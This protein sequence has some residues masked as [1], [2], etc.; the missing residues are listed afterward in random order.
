MAQRD[1]TPLA[2]AAVTFTAH[3]LVAGRYGFFR[4]ELYFIDCGR[5]PALGYAD[6]PPLAPLIAALTQLAGPNLVL[7]RLLPALAHALTVV[8]AATLAR[9]IAVDAGLGGRVAAALTAAA[10]ALSPMYL[11]L[12]TTFG[13][14]TF[15]PLAWTA[16]ALL[17]ARAVSRHDLRALVLAGAVAGIAM[18]FKYALPFYLLPLVVGLIASPDRRVLFNR[19]AAA[20]TAIALLLAA[21][22]VLWQWSHGWPFLE[23]L[24]AAKEKNVA[25]S[26]LEF[27][28]NQVLVMNPVL[29]PLW[30]AGAIVPF[31]SRRFGRVRFLAVGFVGVLLEM[32]FLHGK[33]YYPAPGYA[34]AFALGSSAVEA[35]MPR[36]GS[37]RIAALALALIVCAVAAPTAMPILDPPSLAAY[38]RTLHLGGQ[39]QEKNA[40]GAPIPQ[41]FADMLGW[42]ELEA[43]VA[44]AFHALTPQERARVAIVTSNYGE[45]AALDFFGGKDGL[46]PA[47][48]GHN[49]FY[50]WGP[51]G[52]DGS[53]VLRINGNIERWR[54]ICDDVRLVGT[55][56]VEYSLVYEKDRPILLCRG[57]KKRLDESWSDFK[58]ID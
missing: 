48:S 12:H 41:E 13:T 4:D 28:G 58:H 23:L 30:M 33:D 1:L 47:L 49:Q 50:F 19:Q 45:A 40:V 32:M 36:M 17:V 44:K 5:H 54:D 8:T 26:S 46:P 2:I 10:V 34:A 7:L 18:E 6:Q 43:R 31:L 51:R 39:A 16:I 24:G 29:A 53:V 14:T 55:F 21:P 15:E 37:F 3:A 22:S 38:Q 20:G 35:W 11:G 57:M 42:E 9:L 56:G 25:F 27:L 52:H